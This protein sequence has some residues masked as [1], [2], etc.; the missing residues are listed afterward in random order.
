MWRERVRDSSYRDSM[1]AES[2]VR[3]KGNEGAV[4]PGG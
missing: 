4:D 1:I 3:E 2:L